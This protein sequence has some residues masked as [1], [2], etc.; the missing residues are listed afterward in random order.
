[1][2]AMDRGATEVNM[3]FTCVRICFADLKNC[4]Q[5]G[6]QKNGSTISS[7]IN[8]LIALALLM[9]RLSVETHR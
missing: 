7:N 2:V 4:I 1:M 3:N 8:L 9:I 5:A 6:R